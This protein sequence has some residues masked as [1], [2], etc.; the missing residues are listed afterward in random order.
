MNKITVGCLLLA[1]LVSGCDQSQD[2]TAIAPIQTAQPTNI[3]ETYADKIPFSEYHLEDYLIQDHDLPVGY[4]E[5]LVMENVN[6]YPRLPRSDYVIRQQIKKNN[7]LGGVVTVLL[8]EDERRA[9]LFYDELVSE[10]HD[11]SPV[12][13]NWRKGVINRESSSDSYYIDLLFGHCH[14]VVHIR[15]GETP[16]DQVIAYAER[17]FRR[18][19]RI[20]CG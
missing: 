10:M 4:S 6:V 18:L 1:L 20:G 11:P 2:T 14:L 19:D 3:P 7:H 5:G 13:Y 17:L 8:F 16:E 12:Y 15:L 9:D